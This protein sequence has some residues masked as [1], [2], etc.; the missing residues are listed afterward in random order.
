M[1]S[2][3]LYALTA[4]DTTGLGWLTVNASEFNPQ[5]GTPPSLCA[6]VVGCWLLLA[7]VR[8]TQVQAAAPPALHPWGLLRVTATTQ[9]G[10]TPP[11]SKKGP[12]HLF[13][14]GLWG[15]VRCRNGLWKAD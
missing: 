5:P 1:P 10:P 14:E 6:V 4:A 11:T 9:W 7:V 12:A 15:Q 8:Y 3:C 2:R 13:H